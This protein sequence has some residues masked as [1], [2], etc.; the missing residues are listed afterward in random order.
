[1]EGWIRDFRKF[2]NFKYWKS[3]GK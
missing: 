1:M 3:G 2:K